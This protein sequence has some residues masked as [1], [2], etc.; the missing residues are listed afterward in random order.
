MTVGL[1]ILE[2]A[3]RAKTRLILILAESQLECDKKFYADYQ[4]YFQGATDK[5]LVQMSV[6]ANVTTKV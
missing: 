1:H 3:T 2:M 5:G 4:K 6:L